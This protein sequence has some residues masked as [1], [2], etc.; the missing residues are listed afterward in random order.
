M[1]K[2]T[3]RNK[4]RHQG[5]ECKADLECAMIHMV[6]LGALADERSTYINENLPIIIAGLQM[7]IDSW[8]AFTPGL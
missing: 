8:D 2:R 4:I 3:T 1:A 6:Q 5:A 7:V